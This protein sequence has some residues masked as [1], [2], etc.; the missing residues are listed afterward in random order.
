MI[1]IVDYGAGN[2]GSVYK[3]FR[4][5]GAAAAVTA[6]AGEVDRASALVLPG[7][8]AFSHCMAG[9]EAAALT[10]P[11]RAFIRSGRPF[12]GICVGMQM[13]FA[14]SEEQAAC[15]GLG[16]LGGRVARLQFEGGA[17]TRADGRA[18]K[19]PHIGWN[20]LEFRP[21]ARLFR[22]LSQGDRVYFVHS[23]YPLPEEAD[24]VSATT[25][26]GHRFCCAVEHGNV[27]AT[28]FH[29]EK[30]GQIGLAI[31]RNFVSS[32]S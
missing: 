18:L 4:H 9:L 20:A 12:L 26:Y 17:G 32:C 15:P 30:S 27:H 16:V 29:P 24:D 14:G 19:V 13:L 8:G 2:L 25:D 11:V 1:A 6:D 10:R 31:L 3:A 21:E 28:Q 22:G 5:I 23:Y 7:V